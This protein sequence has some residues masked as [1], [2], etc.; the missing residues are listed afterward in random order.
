MPLKRWA[1]R[2]NKCSSRRRD[3]CSISSVGQW[4]IAW[5]Q[6]HYIPTTNPCFFSPAST[7]NAELLLRPLWVLLATAAADIHLSLSLTSMY[8]VYSLL[9]I[10]LP[11]NLSYSFFFLRYRKLETALIISYQLTPRKNISF[12]TVPIWLVFFILFHRLMHSM[13]ILKKAGRKRERERE[14]ESERERRYWVSK[15]IVVEKD[16]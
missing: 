10:L 7:L 6:I 12:G 2:R 11:W 8:T 13:G 1:Q 15:A 4:T 9:M 14:R 3:C 5:E 16:H